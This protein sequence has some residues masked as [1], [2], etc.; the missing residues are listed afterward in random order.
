VDKM[1][2]SVKTRTKQIVKKA[3]GLGF[4]SPNCVND[5]NIKGL[6]KFFLE[7]QKIKRLVKQ[8]KLIRPYERIGVFEIDNV[9]DYIDGPS[10][11]EYMDGVV[12]MKSLRYQVFKQNL[13]C[14]SCG[15]MGTFFA[16][17]R[18]LGCHRYHFNLYGIDQHGRQVLMTK[19]HI[20]S[21]SRG[22]SDSLTNLQTMCTVC[23]KL[24]GNKHAS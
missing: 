6:I 21:K 9:L 17:E 2:T 11:R 19:D 23:N 10:E 7:T 8:G 15:I 4:I 18:T 16:L 13:S 3:A 22:G 20:I 14:V 1:S 5:P 12:K 24:K